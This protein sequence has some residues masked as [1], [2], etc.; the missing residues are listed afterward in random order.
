VVSGR[1]RGVIGHTAGKKI[2]RRAHHR[3]TPG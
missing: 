2:S 3:R 1:S